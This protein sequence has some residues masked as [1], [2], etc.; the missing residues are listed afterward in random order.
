MRQDRGLAPYVEYFLTRMILK[1][2]GAH[3]A[4]QSC[5]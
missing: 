3:A 5:E 2:S 1:F 4:I